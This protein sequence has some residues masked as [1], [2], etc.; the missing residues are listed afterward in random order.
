MTVAR[1]GEVWLVELGL[2]RVRTSGVVSVPAGG[3]CAAFIDTRQALRPERRYVGLAKRDRDPVPGLGFRSVPRI[4]G[5]REWSV[6]QGQ[7]TRP[8]RRSP[9]PGCACRPLRAQSFP[10]G[11]A[12]WCG[13]CEAAMLPAPFRSLP[14]ARGFLAKAM[15]EEPPMPSSA[16]PGRTV[17]PRRPTLLMVEDDE[18]TAYRRTR[19]LSASG[20]VVT[21]TTTAADALARFKATRFDAVL[22][23]IHLPDGNGYELCR[24]LRAQRAE[25]PVILISATFM[26]DASRAT[27]T[28]AGAAAFLTEP[29][30]AEELSAAIR[31]Q[32]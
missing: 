2:A 11:A 9:Q 20:I 27:A 21:A 23:D 31:A 24:A 25:V 14:H 18:G 5:N 30:S 28:F 12:T 10:I 6:Q 19:E 22:T 3:T 4:T 8:R 15:P 26:D 32:L 17:T 1:R 16:R 7:R 29:I 13:L